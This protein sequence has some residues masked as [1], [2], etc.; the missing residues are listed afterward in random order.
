VLAIASVW[1][2]WRTKLVSVL[3]MALGSVLLAAANSAGAWFG[4]RF[5]LS[6]RGDPLQDS[7]GL[8][9]PDLQI[10]LSYSS[11]ILLVVGAVRL[12]VLQRGGHAGI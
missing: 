3:T 9:S 11:L 6:E 12:L 2:Y 4:P 7:P 1:T 8:M 5:L 10:L